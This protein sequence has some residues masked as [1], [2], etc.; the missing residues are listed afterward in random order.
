VTQDLVLPPDAGK[1]V[2]LASLGVRFMLGGAQTG[3]RFALVEHPMPPRSLGA[4]VHTHHGEDEFSFVIEGEVG[5]QIGD[6]ILT[7]GPGTLVT[8]P[9]GVPHAFWNPGASP[10]RI[11][12][13]I[14][15][16]GL[17][18]Y[19][20]ALAELFSSG[21]PDEVRAAELQRQYHLEMDFTSIPRLLEAY[22]L[23]L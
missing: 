8:K 5:L 17:E 11:L 9:R 16:A 20:E 23:T 15:P 2:K 22:G 1:L 6:Q 19:F 14:S 10:A 21:P 4:P 18:S 13:I 7:A 12:E 3:G